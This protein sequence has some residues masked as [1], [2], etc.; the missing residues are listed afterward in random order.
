MFSLEGE[1]SKQIGEILGNE[2]CKKILNLL[3]EKELSESDIAKELGMKVNT[4]EYNL[5]K[6]ISLGLVEKVNHFWS[7][8]GKKIPVYRA[9]NKHIIIS[10][11]TKAKGF[12]ITG[13]LAIVAAFII[14]VLSYKPI[15]RISEKTD[16]VESMVNVPASSSYSAYPIIWLWFLV[17]AGFA[18]IVLYLFRKFRDNN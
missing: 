3:A 5:R 2:N 17:G 8:R 12:L 18:L 1:E 13:L 11:R 6:L 15:L 7:T 16:M 14:K 9:A 10:P 4:I